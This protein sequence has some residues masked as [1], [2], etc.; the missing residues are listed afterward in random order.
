[1]NTPEEFLMAEYTTL[2][3]F[4]ASQLEQS[5]NRFNFFLALVSGAL[6]IIAL[7]NDRNNAF[8]TPTFFVGTGITALSL[9]Y[10]GIVTYRRIVQTHIRMVEYTRGMNRIRRYFVENYPEIM[11]YLTFSSDDTRPKLGALGS[12]TISA[13]GLTSM[14][15]FINTVLATVGLNFLLFQLT[16]SLGEAQPVILVISV[17]LT[18]GLSLLLHRRDLKKQLAQ[19]DT[20]LE[21]KRVKLQSNG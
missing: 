21:R 2:K 20:E 1:M 13:T 16:L 8:S 6:A 9:L 14:V 19:A 17:V 12:L 18:A 4:R 3:E 5:Q 15:M 10:L 7:V 11:P